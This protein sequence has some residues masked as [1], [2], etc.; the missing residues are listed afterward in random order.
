LNEDFIAASVPMVRGDLFVD[1]EDE[2]DGENARLRP[3]RIA[4]APPA[5]N[6]ASGQDDR[7][8]EQLAALAEERGVIVGAAEAREPMEAKR[9]D[10]LAQGVEV[11]GGVHGSEF[12]LQAV[13]IQDKLL[14]TS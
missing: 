12:S 10:G 6:L 8:G 13:F 9:P 2:S 14:K 11:E 5:G 1:G 3:P 7:G 4:A